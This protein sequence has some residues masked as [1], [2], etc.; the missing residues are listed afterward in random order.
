MATVYT[1]IPCLSSLPLQALGTG[2]NGSVLLA[3]GKTRIGKFAVKAKLPLWE[4]YEE[5]M[6]NV[7]LQ[8]DNLIVVENF[9]WTNIMIVDQNV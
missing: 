4:E 3:R 7:I 1:I 5:F 8:G 9:Y 6:F 2:Y